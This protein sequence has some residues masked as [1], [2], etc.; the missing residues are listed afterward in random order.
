MAPPCGSGVTKGGCIPTSAGAPAGWLPAN[1][2]VA[3]GGKVWH[4]TTKTPLAG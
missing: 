3:D 4:D 2:V 1:V